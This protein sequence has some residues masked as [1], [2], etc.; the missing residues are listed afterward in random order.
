MAS[1]T[2]ITRGVRCPNPLLR[3]W[4]GLVRSGLRHATAMEVGVGPSAGF[5][6][7]QLKF[8]IFPRP[9]NTGDVRWCGTDQVRNDM[10]RGRGRRTVAGIDWGVSNGSGAGRNRRPCSSGPLPDPQEATPCGPADRKAACRQRAQELP[11]NAGH[12]QGDGEADALEKPIH[13]GFDPFDSLLEVDLLKHM[14]L[15]IRSPRGA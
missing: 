13:V 15:R 10:F 5:P 11:G 3:H 14:C 2:C 7:H 1:T 8:V 12:E 6:S 9:R 4:V